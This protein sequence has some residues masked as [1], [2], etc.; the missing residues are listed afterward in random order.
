MIEDSFDIFNAR[1]ATSNDYI[2]GL[3]GDDLLRGGDGFDTLEVFCILTSNL[4]Q[5]AIAGLNNYI[6]T[7]LHS[8]LSSD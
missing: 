3:S 8:L 1:L 7:I 5:L 2:Q 4:P 6:R